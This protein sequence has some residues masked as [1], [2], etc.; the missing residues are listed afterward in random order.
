MA[1]FTKMQTATTNCVSF[2]SLFDLPKPLSEKYTVGAK[3]ASWLR[4]TERQVM[5]LH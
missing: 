2:F 5:P 4:Q 1:E 3:L